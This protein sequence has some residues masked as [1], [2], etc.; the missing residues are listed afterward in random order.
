MRREPRAS[1]VT[2]T[3]EAG[4][5]SHARRWVAQPPPMRR[6]LPGAESEVDMSTEDTSQEAPRGRGS[7]VAAIS[8]MMVGLVREHTGRG[9]TKAGT[10]ISR[11]VVTCVMEDN[12]TKAERSLVDHGEGREVLDLRRIH[13]RFMRDQAIKGVEQILERKVISFMSDNDIDPDLAAETWVL[14][15]V[16]T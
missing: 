16:E 4:S 6:R 3:S 13:Q 15:P 11:D 1:G 9:T 5:L 7:D 14:A 10:V 12:L 2:E 8:N